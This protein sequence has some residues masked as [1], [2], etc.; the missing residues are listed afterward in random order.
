MYENI[1]LTLVP[2]RQKYVVRDM[3]QSAWL[4]ITKYREFGEVDV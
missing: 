3:L 2:N 1:F 4:L